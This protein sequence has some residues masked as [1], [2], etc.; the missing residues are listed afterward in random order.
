MPARSPAAPARRCSRLGEGLHTYRVRAIDNAG[1]TSDPTP[2]TWTTDTG[3]VPAPPPSPNELFNFDSGITAADQDEIK[4]DVAYAVQD[5]AV[6]LGAPITSVSTFV[7]T[8]PDWLAVQECRVMGSTTNCA[9]DT[10]DRYAGA[11]RREWPAP[12]QSSSIGR[13]Q[14]GGMAPAKTR[15]SSRTNSSTFSS[16]SATCS[17][18]VGRCLPATYHPERPGLAR[19]RGQRKWSATAPRSTE[20]SSRATRAVLAG[21]ISRQSKSV[22]RSAHL[23]GASTFR[24]RMSTASSTSQSTIS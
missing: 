19:S 6:L 9:P 13:T 11:A 23:K 4:G 2:R 5:E 1:N 7:S 17:S 8:S 21:Q 20:G 12:A 3:P 24:S 15:R 18:I 16:T 22:R 14:R 10:R